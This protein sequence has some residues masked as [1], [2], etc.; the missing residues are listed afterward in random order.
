M[1]DIEAILRQRARA[2][3]GT[4][5]HGWPDRWWD[6][7]TVRCANDHVST[8]VL[9]SEGRGHDVCLACRAPVHLT[10]PEDQDGPLSLPIDT[11]V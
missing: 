10:F 11:A 1:A 2:E 5:F 3:G 8:R 6:D 7:Y 9:K 4:T